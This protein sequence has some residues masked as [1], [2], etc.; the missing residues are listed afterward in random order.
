VPPLSLSL[1]QT[2]KQIKSLKKKKKKRYSF[3]TP[4][5]SF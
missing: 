2:N 3:K 1:S 4:G 5:P